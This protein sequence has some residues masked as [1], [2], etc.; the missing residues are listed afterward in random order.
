MARTPPPPAPSP[1]AARL[2]SA[3]RPDGSLHIT[4][5]GLQRSVWNDLFHTLLTLHRRGFTLLLF[6]SYFVVN[7]CFAVLYLLGGDCIQGARPGSLLDAFEF[8][9][10]TF[11][12]IGYGVLSPSTT[13]A[14]MLVAM[15][16]LTGILYSAL[17]TG[18]LFARFSRPTARVMF[19][20]Y[21]TVG[22]YHGAPTLTYRVANGRFN[23]IVEANV[24]IRLS[25][26]DTS[27][28]GLV[29]RRLYD[30]KLVRDTNPIFALSWSIFHVIDPESPL[31][32]QTPESL[33]AAQAMLIIGLTG[34]DETVAATVHARKNLLWDQ[35]LWNHR[36]VDILQGNA[37]SGTMTVD[38]TKFHATVPMPP[39][40]RLHG[41]PV[42]V[43]PDAPP[44]VEEDE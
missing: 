18:L 44:P 5:I 42:S 2:Q 13:Y 37:A 23:Q 29:A 3:L 40:Q 36:Y 27:P 11:A 21:A 39:E 8:S 15:E 24:H 31:F 26:M 30:L 38:Y 32:G 14:H 9:V 33:E 17:A 43:R 16:A 25:R 10:Q 19:S 28:E 6:G 20:Q 12:T 34:T 22:L 4:R 41:L 7:L 35:V 1:A